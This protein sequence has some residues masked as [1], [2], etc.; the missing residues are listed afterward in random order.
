MTYFSGQPKIH[1]E[2]INIS[3]KDCI[4]PMYD[5]VLDDILHH[6]HTH[7]VFPGGR[8]STKSSFVGGIAI[9]LLI[10][11]N[12]KCHAI[13]FR[14]VGNTIQNSIYSQVV[15]G[16]YHLGLGELFYI[17]KTYANPII[18]RPT[19]QRIY[20]MGLDNPDKVKFTFGGDD[21]IGIFPS[22]GD[23]LKFS[24]SLVQEG[25]PLRLMVAAGG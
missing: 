5:D 19:G 7:Y 14:K 18:Y 4:I 16:I 6:Q 2:C 24:L 13:C 22:S 3:I 12:P 10:V 15:W 17:P 20:F 25:R 9:P 1:D 21:N 11:Q 8:G 23:Q